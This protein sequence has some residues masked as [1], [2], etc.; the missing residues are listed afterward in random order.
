MLMNI[1]PQ[2]FLKSEGDR[3]HNEF[4]GAKEKDDVHAKIEE[5]MVDVNE[6][7]TN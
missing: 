2:R 6:A 1:Q 5:M 3:Y 4:V 7:E